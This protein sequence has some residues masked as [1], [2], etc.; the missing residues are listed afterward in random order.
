M[1]KPL[2]ISIKGGHENKLS[3]SQKKKLQLWIPQNLSLPLSC[4]FATWHQATHFTSF[5][6]I[7]CIKHT[8]KN[9]QRWVRKS[10][11]NLNLLLPWQT[12]RQEIPF[13]PEKTVLSE[14]N[15]T[16]DPIQSF[17]SKLSLCFNISI[18]LPSVTHICKLFSL[19]WYPNK[20]S[21]PDPNGWNTWK[22]SPK[23][24]FWN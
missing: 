6:S 16:F 8:T 24:L 21:D 11:K 10:K 22:I 19:L 9:Q 18:L 13:W 4:L 14:T 7:W 1:M 3:F 20:K 17:V 2:L 5:S 23:T 12:I 15:L